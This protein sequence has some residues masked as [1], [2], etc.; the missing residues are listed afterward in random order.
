MPPNSETMTGIAGETIVWLTAAT[1][2]P[3][4]SPTKITFLWPVAFFA[5][6]SPSV[7]HQPG[8]D[9]ERPPEFRQLLLCKPLP[10]TLLESLTMLLA[11]LDQVP[12][13]RGDV[14]SHHP[15]V[16]RI[17]LPAQQTLPLEPLRKARDA[18]GVD[19]EPVAN[20]P[21]AYPVLLDDHAQE[22]PRRRAQ[23]NLTLEGV[24]HP[25]EGEPQKRH[26]RTVV[27]RL[28]RQHLILLLRTSVL[29]HL[30]DPPSLIDS[31]S[32]LAKLVVS[33][34]ICLAHPG[35]VRG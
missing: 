16:L 2:M 14:Q 20:L 23:A 7:L 29:Q 24:L 22:E 8:D 31:A 1:S 9:A 32:I 11:A 26:Q 30:V 12:P 34:K 18:R 27:C 4:I 10:E 17:S 33:T 28:L 21:L 3:S 19:L 13:L 6:Y 5:I 25:P 35:P 15:V